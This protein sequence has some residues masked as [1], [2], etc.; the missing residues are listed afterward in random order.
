MFAVD[1]SR[2]FSVGTNCKKDQNLCSEVI[3]SV[4]TANGTTMM[5]LYDV[6]YVTSHYHST[7]PTTLS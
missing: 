2:H 6:H 1:F 7:R 3:I 4:S 5:P